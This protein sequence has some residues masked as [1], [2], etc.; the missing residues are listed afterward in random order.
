MTDHILVEH[1]GEAERR[2][3][4]IRFNRPDKK[5]AI[6]RAMYA[7]MAAAIAEGE[8]DPTVRVHV[9]L[10]TPGAFTSGNDLQDFMAVAMGAAA[11]TEV[12]D[13]MQA[14]ATTAKPVISGVDG[15]AVG[16]GAT[17]QL[18]C[19]LT[20]ATPATRFHT[21]F[22]DLGLVPEFGSS[23]M[24]PLAIGHQR[25]FAMLAA[26]VPISA[27]DACAAGLIY[28]VVEADMLEA[29]VLAAAEGLAAKPPEALAIA[30]R[31]IKGDPEER[32]ARIAEET[33]LFA[34]RLKSA[35]AMQAF[36]AFM[37]RKK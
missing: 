20:F 24:V 4:V 5:N 33:K 23:L 25:A 29:A 26:G 28:Q 6:T 7:A 11:G 13:F 9:L 34:S 32:L 36:Q 21:P 19:D 16:I 18:H 35:E 31:L 12:W 3:Q 10:G 1:Q 17:I 8:A 27:G 15:I 37:T 2:I 14:L 22:V 30:R